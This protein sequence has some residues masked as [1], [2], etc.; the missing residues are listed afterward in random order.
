[1]FVDNLIGAEATREAVGGDATVQGTNHVLLKHER[2]C[3]IPQVFV[4]VGDVVGDVSVVVTIEHTN[5]NDPTVD[6]DWDAWKVVT[7]VTS[8]GTQSADLVSVTQATPGRKLRAKA[9]NGDSGT[10]TIWVS[11]N[12]S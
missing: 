12:Q 3:E 4:R 8:E 11:V 6:A 5:S 1:M 9:V 2:R 7:A 10:C